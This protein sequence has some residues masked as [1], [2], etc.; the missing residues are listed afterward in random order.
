MPRWLLATLLVAILTAL[1]LAGGHQ[2]NVSGHY[3]SNW[4]NVRLVQDGDRVTGTYVCCG[5]GTIEG[6]ISEGRTIRYRWR[7]PGGEGLGVW[8]IDGPQLQGTWGSGAS[9]DNGGRWDLART[10]AQGQIA[11]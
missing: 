6:R 2:V 11:R 3:K 7:Q 9:A 1:A 5:G 8:L 4:D 10:S